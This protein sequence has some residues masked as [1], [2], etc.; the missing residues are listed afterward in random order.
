MSSNL[1]NDW[2][3]EASAFSSI[4]SIQRK[5][6]REKIDLIYHQLLS[7]FPLKSFERTTVLIALDKRNWIHDL[8]ARYHHSGSFNSLYEIAI[9]IQYCDHFGEPLMSEIGKRKKDPQIL[10]TLF[11]ELFIYYNLDR[12][13]IP[14]NKILKMGNQVVE[15]TCSIMGR[16]FLFECRKLFTPQLHEFDIVVRLMKEIEKMLQSFQLM[17]GMIGVIKF[18]GKIQNRHYNEFRLRLEAFAACFK[19]GKFPL[20]NL[21]YIISDEFGTFEVKEFDEA[22]K[23]EIEA[24]N[25]YHVLFTVKPPKYVIADVPSLYLVAV[26]ANYKMFKS[27]TYQNFESALKE[28]KEQHKGSTLK[29]KILF[30]DCEYLSEIQMGMFYSES[31]YDSNKILKLYNKLGLDYIL[32]LIRRDYRHERPLIIT[33]VYFRPNDLDTSK[34]LKQIISPLGDIY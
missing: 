33:D 25:D 8:L 12:S 13:G 24:S 1:L 10:R 11:F 26:D 28:K 3:K 34:L 30:F 6:S 15:G 14:N 19:S 21:N 16:E 27:K 9:L 29:D 4:F 22:S 7:L 31:F 32:C 18:K 2:Y 20:N 17:Y 5:Y 23:V